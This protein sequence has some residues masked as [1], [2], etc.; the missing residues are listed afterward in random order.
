V[1]FGTMLR[2][3]AYHFILGTH[4]ERADNTARISTSSTNAV[5]S[6]ADVGGASIHRESCALSVRVVPQD[7]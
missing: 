6:A 1:T 7:L 2:D 3:E 5:A 4:I